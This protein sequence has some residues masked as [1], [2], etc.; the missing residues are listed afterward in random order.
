M[1][2]FVSTVEPY[3]AVFVSY[4]R[5]DAGIV[6]Q[7]ER[8]YAALGFDYLRDV[9][10][11]RSGEK[12][13]PALL[14]KIEEADIF[15]LC[16]SKAAKAS[17]NVEQEW[18]HAMRLNRTAFVTPALLGTAH[19]GAARRTKRHPLRAPRKLNS[20]A[21]SWPTPTFERLRKPARRSRPHV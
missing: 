19:A 7:L 16:W 20:Q 9:R 13:N 6:D 17:A 14:R 10:V 3:Q 18:R 21:T 5:Q 2:T 4:A 8:A 11:L 1:S 12:W 15:Q